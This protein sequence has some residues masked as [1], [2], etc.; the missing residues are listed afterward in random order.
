MLFVLTLLG[1]KQMG[2][3][4]GYE[5]AFIVVFILSSLITQKCLLLIDART[6]GIYMYY[7]RQL[8]V[9]YTALVRVVVRPRIL[10]ILDSNAKL[11]RS[12]NQGDLKENAL[13]CHASDF[14]LRG[15]GRLFYFFFICASRQTSRMKL[16]PLSYDDLDDGDGDEH[17]LSR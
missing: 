17:P 1:V 4:V 14:K 11:R 3:P 6:R 5:A 12:I 8:F 9:Y 7:F 15:F 2:I 10:H 13:T 16:S